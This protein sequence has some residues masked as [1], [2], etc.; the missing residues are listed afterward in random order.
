MK[1]ECRVARLPTGAGNPSAEVKSGVTYSP[2]NYAHAYVK[3]FQANWLSFQNPS[4]DGE[5][6]LSVSAVTGRGP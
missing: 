4:A 1:M 2:A 6:S 5:H 3:R